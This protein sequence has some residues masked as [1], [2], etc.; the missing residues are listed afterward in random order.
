MCS[1]R[2]Q[3]LKPPFSVPYFLHHYRVQLFLNTIEALFAVTS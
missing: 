2:Y 1:S 3:C